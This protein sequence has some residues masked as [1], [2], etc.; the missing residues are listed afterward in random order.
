MN[1]NASPTPLSTYG[2]KRF[3]QNVPSVGSCVYQK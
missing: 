3:F 2:T 1:T